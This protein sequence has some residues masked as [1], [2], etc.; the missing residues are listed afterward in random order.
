[1][2]YLLTHEIP[3]PLQNIKEKFAA[4]L[5]R[6]SLRRPQSLLEG[7]LREE[8]GNN[9]VVVPTAETL[10]GVENVGVVVRGEDGNLGEEEG[11]EGG[12]LALREG[13]YFQ[14]DG[15]VWVSGEVLVV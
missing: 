12:V 2:D 3:Q 5:L 6:D 15:F 4:I 8:L 7:P 10:N 9:I 1:M 11:H 13:D 14:G